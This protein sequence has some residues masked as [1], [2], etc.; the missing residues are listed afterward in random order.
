MLKKAI[1]SLVWMPSYLKGLLNSKSGDIRPLHVLF[2]ICDHYEPYWNNADKKTARKRV[3]TW[4]KEYPP[5]AEKYRDSDG[6]PFVYSF[7]YPEEEYTYEDMKA[8]SEICAA[9]LGEVEIHLHHDNDTSVNLKRTL[10]DYKK[11]LHEQHGLLSVDKETGDISYGF[12]HG[13]WALCNSR[14]DGRQCGVNDEIKILK[15][16]GCFADFTMPSAPD[17]TQT[18]K[19]NSI[20]YALDRP[21]KPKSHDTGKDVVAGQKGDGLL[22]VQGP[23][24]FNWNKRKRGIIPSLENGGVLGSNPPTSDRINLWIDQHIHVSGLPN[25]VFVKIYTHG[26]QEKIMKVLFDEKYLEK[27]IQDLI[28]WS[29]DGQDRYIHFVSAREMANTVFAIEEGRTD[30]VEEMRDHRFTTLRSEK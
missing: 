27:M 11:R 28:Q 2:S 18:R 19:I 26:T 20:Y 24:C 9:N 1:N 10:I 6:R 17:I 3:G 30:F 29:D 25:I 8:L 22:M 23:L 4:L 15:E 14:P 5:I 21:G 16:T 12:I 7:F 13:N